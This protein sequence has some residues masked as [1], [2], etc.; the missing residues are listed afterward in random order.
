[1]MSWPAPSAELTTLAQSNFAAACRDYYR[2]TAV[3]LAD[4]TVARPRLHT[5]CNII[6][7]ARDVFPA[8]VVI[9]QGSIRNP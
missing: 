6:R 3:K 7:F 8:A 4:G 1:M 2:N 9:E 5:V